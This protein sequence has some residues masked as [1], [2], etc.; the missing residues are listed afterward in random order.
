M[1]FMQKVWLLLFILV[2]VGGCS[3]DTTTF[4]VTS[5]VQGDVDALERVLDAMDDVDFVVFLGDANQYGDSVDDVE[6]MK[7]VFGK[8]STLDE[9]VYVLPG[10]H[11]N[12]N[13]YYVALDGMGLI[14][15]SSSGFV[16]GVGLDF[17]VVSGY[18]IVGFPSDDGFVFDE[19][20]LSFVSD[21][22][23]VLFAH[24][25]PFDVGDEVYS[26]E[27][28]GSEIVTDFISENKL[29]FG[30]FGHIH[31]SG[32]VALDVDGKVVSEGVWSD[33]LFLNVGSVAP[34][35][36]LS[37]REH[38]GMGAVVAFDGVKMKYELIEG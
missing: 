29:L 28:V 35:T 24:G 23:V 27:H 32:G 6:E 31:E 15:L 30:F 2:F 11:E 9:P 36:L 7:N 17:V 5:D 12:K 14:D 22:P 20:D 21:D 10:N 18:H 26:G 37:G 33:S 38:N 4:G 19:I 25:P 34:W 16:D 13:D 8:L 3:D 1:G